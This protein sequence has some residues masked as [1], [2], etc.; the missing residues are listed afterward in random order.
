MGLGE[1]G[2]RRRIGLG[3][4]VIKKRMDA[5]LKVRKGGWVKGR[6]GNE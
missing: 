6:E 5:T 4:E 3:K 2:G 1:Q